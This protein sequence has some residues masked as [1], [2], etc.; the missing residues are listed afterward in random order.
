LSPADLDFLKNNGVSGRVIAEMQNARPQSPL[1][2]RVVVR[3]PQPVTAVIYQEP[4]Y[5]P[6][7]FVVPHRHYCA[8]RPVI[9]AGGVIP[10]R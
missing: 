7:V 9:Y 6:P 8:P 5:P 1:A 3:D 4:A 10:I 2:T